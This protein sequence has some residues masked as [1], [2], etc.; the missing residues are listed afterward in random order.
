MLV[1]AAGAQEPVTQQSTMCF[2]RGQQIPPKF[3]QA[4]LNS[5]YSAI[6]LS[7]NP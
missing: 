5:S 7:I 6:T 2:A 4:I 1:V 3:C